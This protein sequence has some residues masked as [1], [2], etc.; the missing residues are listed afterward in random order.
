LRRHHSQHVSIGI[1]NA[2]LGNANLEIHTC[3]CSDKSPVFLLRLIKRR[4]FYQKGEK[5]ARTK[6]FPHASKFL[7]LV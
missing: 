3:E 4:R 1:K 5:H 6:R 7:F 2:N